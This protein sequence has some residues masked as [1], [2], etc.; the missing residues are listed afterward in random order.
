MYFS[1]APIRLIGLHR[2]FAF[3]LFTCFCV[4]LWKLVSW[5]EDLR[6]GVFVMRMQKCVGQ[7][8]GDWINCIKK[9]FMMYAVHRILFAR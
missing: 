6:L 4:G 1:A 9:S 5:A 8:K 3:T 7:S 2:N